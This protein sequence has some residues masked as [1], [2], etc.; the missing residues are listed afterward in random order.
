MGLNIQP[1]CL[2]SAGTSRRAKVL[3]LTTDRSVGEIAERLS[4]CTPNYFF[5]C[6][7]ED[8]GQTP[9]RYRKAR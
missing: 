8:T 3:L 1:T 5:K 6:F 2:P 9:A 4:F 7:R